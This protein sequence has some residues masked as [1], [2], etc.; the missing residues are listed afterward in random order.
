MQ[1]LLIFAVVVILALFG[2]S[3]VQTVLM[4]RTV[5]RVAESNEHLRSIHQAE[6][7]RNAAL[8]AERDCLRGPSYPQPNPNDPVCSRDP[9]AFWKE[10]EHDGHK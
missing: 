3:V 1:K 2:S 10:V 9:A 7:T 6:E 8:K 4:Y 5:D